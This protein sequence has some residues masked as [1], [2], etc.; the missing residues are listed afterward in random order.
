MG[1][2]RAMVRAH[3]VLTYYVVTFAI[4]WGGV[5][6]VVGPGGAPTDKETL[7]RLL[8]WA[9][10][11]MIAGPLVAGLLVTGLVDGRAGY[12]EV[13]S[14]LVTWRVGL[15]WYAV[16]LLLSPLVSLAV[17]FALSTFSP[18]FVPGIF[19]TDDRAGRL[20]FG[21]TAGLAVGVCE[22]IG[23]MG[24]AVPRIRRRH[25]A[26]ATGVIA[27]VL[28]GAWHL[29]GQV[30]MASGS[31]AGTLPPEAFFALRTVAM[32]AG[33]L[34]AYRVL[35]VGLYDRTGS[36]PIMILMHVSLTAST[37]IFEPAA[38]SGMSLV[39][40]DV[41]SAAAWWAIVA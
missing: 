35:M 5:L 26:I 16:A 15:R 32:I 6:L 38:I 22:E 11:L 31:Y 34:V 28:W 41:A 18:V 27:G 40:Y 10:G 23:W 30:V 8:P 7:A 9:I 4:S 13:A 3:P 25:G 33:G 14:R 2:I 20:L 37:L 21:L 12:R 29:A 24:C 1:A 36:L 19:T 39:I 17:L